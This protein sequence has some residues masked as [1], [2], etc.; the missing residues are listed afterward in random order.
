M[1]TI[2]NNPNW[3]SYR[4]SMP[5][6]DDGEVLC[7]SK[8]WIDELNPTGLRV[9]FMDGDGFTTAKW[10]DYQDTYENDMKIEPSYWRPLMDLLNI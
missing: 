6:N 3:I 8:H 10:N 9:G 4:D 1:T 7:Y 5:T 2:E